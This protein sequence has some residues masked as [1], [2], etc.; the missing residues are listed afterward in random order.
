[1][2]SVWARVFAP[3]QPQPKM[4]PRSGSGNR[5]GQVFVS[6]GKAS[7]AILAL[8]R[9]RSVDLIVMGVSGRGALDVALLGSTTPHVSREG[10]RP[11]L[12]VVAKRSVYRL[13]ASTRPAGRSNAFPRS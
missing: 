9:A 3:A 1:M 4:L 8:A 5:R 10:E 2:A 12:T 11:V 7:P 13:R 6:M